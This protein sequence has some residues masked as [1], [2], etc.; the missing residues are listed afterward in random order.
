MCLGIAMLSIVNI[1]QKFSQCR[2]RLGIPCSTT[3]EIILVACGAE[4]RRDEPPLPPRAG[5]ESRG[6]EPPLPPRAGAEPRG[7]EG[8][9]PHP[10]GV[11]HMPL[12]CPP[13]AGLP[14][15]FMVVGLTRSWCSLSSFLCGGTGHRRHNTSQHIAAHQSTLQHIKAHFT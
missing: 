12:P 6:D 3:I 9:L 1:S 14:L 7:V 10:L 5:A 8:P 2:L 15:L 4:T 13:E 11:R